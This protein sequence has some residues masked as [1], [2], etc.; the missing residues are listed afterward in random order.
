[1]NKVLVVE[2]WTP[3]IEAVNYHIWRS[4]NMKCKFCFATYDSILPSSF[5][6]GLPLADAKLLVEALQL[7]GFR[8]LTFA[9]GEPTLCPWLIEVV[10]YAREV[11]LKTA[12]VSNGSRMTC[13]LIEALAPNLD[14]V[15]LSIDSCSRHV[16]VAQGRAV[17]GRKPMSTDTLVDIAEQ[18]RRR[19]VRLKINTVVTRLNADEILVPV[20]E[21]VRPERW[22]IMRVLEIAGENDHFMKLLTVSDE[23]F[24]NF[25]RRNSGIPPGTRQIVED[26]NDMIASYV[27]V[28][29]G[30]RFIDNNLNAYSVSAPILAVG[31]EA[32][33]RDVSLSRKAFE[34]RGGSYD[35]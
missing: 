4:C 19:G 29:P 10:A 25:V 28:D 22:K 21:R 31:V 35:W 14:W 3:P 20:V 11:G 30:G 17:G 18:F 5:A 23:G 6:N 2:Q 16:N 12:L 8:K 9:G 27:M 1:M 34:E 26:N 7:S 32:A 24:R 15:A 13:E 33:L